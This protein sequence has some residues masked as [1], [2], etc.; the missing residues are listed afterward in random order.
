MKKKGSQILTIPAQAVPA[1]PEAATTQDVVLASLQTAVTG[2]A[3]MDRV[4]SA[5]TRRRASGVVDMPRYVFANEAVLRSV[6]NYFVTR[7]SLI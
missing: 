7:K 3:F 6:S 2:G 4:F 5:Y 1:V